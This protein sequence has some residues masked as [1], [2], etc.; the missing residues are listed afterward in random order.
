MKE[1]NSCKTETHYQSEPSS[2]YFLLFYI[3]IIIF[4]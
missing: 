1:K 3:R 2:Y 4:E